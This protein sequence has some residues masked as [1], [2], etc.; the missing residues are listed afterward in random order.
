MVEVASNGEVHPG[1]EGGGK[2]AHDHAVDGEHV[3]GVVGVPAE[4]CC[5]WI[6][7]PEQQVV[8]M[9]NMG[10]CSSFQRWKNVQI[11]QIYLCF[12]SLAMLIF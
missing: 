1:E 10:G 3:E 5:F 2:E 8:N 9:L 11:L 4:F 12:F 7:R 6:R